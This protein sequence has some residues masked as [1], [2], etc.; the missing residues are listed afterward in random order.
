MKNDIY[1]VLTDEQNNSVISNEHPLVQKLINTKLI[2]TKRPEIHEIDYVSQYIDEHGK[3]V[4]AMD[5]D[6]HIHKI[7]SA[8]LPLPLFYPDVPFIDDIELSYELGVINRTQY[9]HLTDATIRST[10][11]Y[12][13]NK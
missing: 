7:Y 12:F 5:H 3:A 6:E 8:P 10:E 2:Y 9:L 11:R 13:E 4:M 1:S